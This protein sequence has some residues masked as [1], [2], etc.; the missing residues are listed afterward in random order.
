[1]MHVVYDS[2]SS[3]KS[4]LHNK[5]ILNVFFQSLPTSHIQSL[6]N[7]EASSLPFS[8]APQSRM[9]R[10]AKTY[11]QSYRSEQKWQALFLSRLFII[12]ASKSTSIR[13]NEEHDTLFPLHQALKLHGEGRR[14]EENN[15]ANGFV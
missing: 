3:N 13:H 6:Y 12:H 1:M 11:I 2:S 5:K 15:N 14:K 10:T 7:C 9:N 4:C 8:K